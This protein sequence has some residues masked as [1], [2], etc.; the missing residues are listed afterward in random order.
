MA[1]KYFSQNIL[2]KN[3]PY[4]ARENLCVYLL[5]WNR[6]MSHIFSVVIAHI[7]GKN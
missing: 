2:T 3:T 7:G 5:R 1:W 6:I 4:L